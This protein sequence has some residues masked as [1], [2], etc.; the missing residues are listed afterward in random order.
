MVQLP[1]FPK[2]LPSA[3]ILATDC[4]RH[5]GVISFDRRITALE[6]AMGGLLGR[7]LSG[8]DAQGTEQIVDDRLLA[9]Y[10]SKELVDQRASEVTA[11]VCELMKQ[12]TAPLQAISDTILKLNGRVEVSELRCQELDLLAKNCD[13]GLT[14]LEERFVNGLL[15]VSESRCQE[16]DLLVKNCDRGLTRLEERFDSLEERQDSE[17]VPS[18]RRTAAAVKELQQ[19]V[20]MT[21]R[22]PSSG[23][24][25]DGDDP[26][27][28]LP[29][30]I[31]QAFDAA[32]CG[33]D[34]LFRSLDTDFFL[35]DVQHQLCNYVQP[36]R[37]LSEGERLA[38][39]QELVRR[40]ERARAG[41][42]QEQFEVD[43]E[44]SDAEESDKLDMHD[45]D[46]DPWVERACASPQQGP[47][48]VNSEASDAEEP[49][50]LDIN[51]FDDDDP[52]EDNE[53]DDFNDG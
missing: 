2:S 21:G 48:A 3:D 5:D 51:D 50:E 8:A 44:A 31:L 13:R 15:E 49:V 33:G 42:Q 12:V 41:P 11:Q 46:D 37:I 22:V 25:V 23:G 6:I 43:S 35:N 19:H 17:I 32:L 53:Y 18:I 29:P 40:C 4:V 27:A 16:L 20:K 36:G 39:R 24:R 28:D 26:F 38:V 9:R 7:S 52:W 1:T 34:P 14:V 45:F 10:A 47:L 30:P